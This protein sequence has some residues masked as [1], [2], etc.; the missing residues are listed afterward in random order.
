MP[1][2]RYVPSSIAGLFLFVAALGGWGVVSKTLG[3]FSVATSPMR[4]LPPAITLENAIRDYA[5]NFWTI[6]AFTALFLLLTVHWT[7]LVQ[8]MYRAAPLATA[9]GAFFLGA[10]VI[11]GIVIGLDVLRVNEF[12]VQAG[13]GAADQQSWY[14]P[15]QR[16]WLLGGINFLLQTHLAYVYGWFL[17]TGLG[18]SALAIG[19]IVRLRLHR[20]FGVL[21]LI[22]GVSLVAGVFLRLW[23]PAYGGNP[24]ALTRVQDFLIDG[25]FALGLLASAIIGLRIEIMSRAEQRQ[26]ATTSAG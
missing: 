19:V 4:R 3:M 11:L 18:L 13:R 26:T 2:R 20:A 5:A 16:Q 14:S 1:L 24:V 9:V 22:S 8:R 12:A 17:C 15:E 25:G 10:S 23:L 6:V 21:G 7:A